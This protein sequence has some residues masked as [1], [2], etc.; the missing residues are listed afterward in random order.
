MDKIEFSL[1]KAPC[2]IFFLSL[3]F[4]LLSSIGI[5]HLNENENQHLTRITQ[6]V[7]ITR[8]TLQKRL[9]ATKLYQNWH[10]VFPKLSRF[11]FQKP[12]KLHW[13]ENIQQ[14][15]EI[16]NLPSITYNIKA[17]QIEPKFAI[18]VGGH[19]AIFSTEIEINAGFIHEQQLLDFFEQLQQ[20]GLGLFS[21]EKCVLTTNGQV[22]QFQPERVN[23][24]AQC[25][26]KW[27]TVNEQKIDAF[28]FNSNGL[29]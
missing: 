23:V 14:Q 18:D 28:D 9:E 13:L 5:D 20:S 2:L 12:D 25:Q 15:A 10:Q 26:I 4:A 11:S 24:S 1:I 19:S 8:N 3:L 6:S 27:Y 29:M 16:L 7:N 17:Q 22:G 21:V